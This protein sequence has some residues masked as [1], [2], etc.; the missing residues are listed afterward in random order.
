MPNINYGN[1]L[2]EERI[3]RKVSQQKLAEA[4]GVTKRTIAYWES[5]KRKMTLDN[6]EKAFKALNINLILTEVKDE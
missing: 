5:G 1:R 2:R 3:K 4:I 6:A